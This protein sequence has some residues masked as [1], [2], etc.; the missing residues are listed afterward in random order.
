MYKRQG[1]GEEAQATE[2]IEIL[3]TGEAISIAFNPTFLADGL[4]ALEQ[5]LFK[6]HLLVQTNLRS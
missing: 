1:A 5:S 6:S 3:L 2:A 4:N